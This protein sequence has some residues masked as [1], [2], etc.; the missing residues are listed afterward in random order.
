MERATKAI[1]AVEVILP[2]AAFAAT[3]YTRTGLQ[4][5]VLAHDVFVILS[6]VSALL[7]VMSFRFHAYQSKSTSALVVLDYATPLVAIGTAV[8]LNENT[9]DFRPRR[10]RH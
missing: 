7:D 6:I 8:Q 9:T 1:G 5:D 10:L 3:A 2:L 4:I